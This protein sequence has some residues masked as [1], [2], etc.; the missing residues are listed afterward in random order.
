M[1]SDDNYFFHHYDKIKK[2]IYLGKPYR[3]PQALCKGRFKQVL[4]C[5]GKEEK[6]KKRRRKKKKSKRE[7]PKRRKNPKKNWKRKG[8]TLPS[9]NRDGE[10]LLEGQGLRLLWLDCRWCWKKGP[11]LGNE[12]VAHWISLFFSF[13]F[14]S[15]LGNRDVGEET[16]RSWR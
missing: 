15:R 3:H 4:N 8:L 16:T 1:K 14:F 10:W 5:A 7:N 13:F 9:L 12:L 6:K 11:S 2:I